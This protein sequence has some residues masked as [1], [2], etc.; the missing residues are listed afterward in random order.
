MEMRKLFTIIRQKNVV[1]ANTVRY[2][3]IRIGRK[4]YGGRFILIKKTILILIFQQF[5]FL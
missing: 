3:P 2:S 5:D 4:R 1:M